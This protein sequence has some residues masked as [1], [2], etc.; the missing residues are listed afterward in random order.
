MAGSEICTRYAI[1]LSK[2]PRKQ[3]WYFCNKPRALFEHKTQTQHYYKAISNQRWSVGAQAGSAG[4]MLVVWQVS[5]WPD[6]SELWEM[7]FLMSGVGQLGLGLGA[8]LETSWENV[9]KH[10]PPPS[11]APV[12]RSARRGLPQG[13]NRLLCASGSNMLRCLVQS[14]CKCKE[15][16]ALKLWC[17]LCGISL[18]IYFLSIL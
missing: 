14:K 13:H 15:K 8:A 5:R 4:A 11:T 1:K 9:V 10:D 16:W 17:V 12:T 7:T 3:F 2:W 18:I 6:L